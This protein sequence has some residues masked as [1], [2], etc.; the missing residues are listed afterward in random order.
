MKIDGS[1]ILVTGGGS[2]IGRALAEHFHKSG[3]KVVIAGRRDDAL[4]EVVDANPGMAKLALD[5]SS[6][7]E[8]A[9]FAALLLAQ[10]PDVDVVVN[11]A[12]I[13]QPEDLTADP[14][15]LSTA[16]AEI[17]INLLG[18]IRLTAA[19]LPHLK[20]RPQA[21][22]VNVSSGLAFVPVAAFP[23]YCAT[24]AAIHSY[25]QSL[26][27]QLRETHVDVLEIAPPYVQT[28]LTGE[29]QA[30]DPRAMP[31]D[32]FIA[33]AVA[34]LANPPASGEILVER[35]NFQRRAEAESRYEEAFAALNGHY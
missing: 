22:I 6:G 18:P 32:E 29:E 25:S 13:M 7:A 1:T 16:E 9:N 17:A 10:H 33:E 35:V 12:G 24:K 14:V 26:R 20:G 19:L 8:I 21:T 5:V 34:I 11:N 23:T 3:A 4:Q 30:N 27:H 31:L 15:D 2:G 28:H